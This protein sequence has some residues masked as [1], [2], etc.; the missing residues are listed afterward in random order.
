MSLSIAALGTG[1]FLPSK[2]LAKNLYSTSTV[3]K[4]GSFVFFSMTSVV[5]SAEL[6]YLVIQSRSDGVPGLDDW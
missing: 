3:A 6:F 1:L 5:A 4:M 2:Y